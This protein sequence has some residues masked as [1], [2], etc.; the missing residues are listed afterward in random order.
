MTVSGAFLLTAH[1]ACARF[2]F[3]GDLEPDEKRDR[4]EAGSATLGS[5]PLSD[6]DEDV[7]AVKRLRAAGW[8]GDSGHRC[9]RRA[10]R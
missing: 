1:A 5:E 7:T 9:G 10:S 8:R 2:S 6:D 3:G 4:L